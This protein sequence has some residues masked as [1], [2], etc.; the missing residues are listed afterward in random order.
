MH[1]YIH[2]H[3]Y[4]HT[5]RL[6]CYLKV[7]VSLAH[8]ASQMEPM[9]SPPVICIDVSVCACLSVPLCTCHSF[10]ANV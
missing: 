7:T 1:A 10:N 5:V 3:T 4:I 8:F 9:Q 6:E 2:I